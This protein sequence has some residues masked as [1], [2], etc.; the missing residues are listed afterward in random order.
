MA[1]ILLHKLISVFGSPGILLIVVVCGFEGRLRFSLL[2]ISVVARS[3]QE[4]AN[5]T[6]SHN[7]FVCDAGKIAF[8]I[9]VTVR[10][11]R[12]QILIFSWTLIQDCI[13]LFHLIN[14]D[15]TLGKTEPPEIALL[16]YIRNK[17]L[18][19]PVSCS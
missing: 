6:R 8:G 11:R 4:I 7:C 14:S 5:P 18:L 2:F 15:S 16:N 19:R 10:T 13:C 9:A 1:G 3:E 12:S 17:P